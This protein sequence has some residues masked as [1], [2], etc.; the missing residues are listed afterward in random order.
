MLRYGVIADGSLRMA[1]EKGEVKERYWNPGDIF[2]EVHVLTLADDDIE[3]E[4]VQVMAGRG[5]LQIHPIGKPRPQDLLTLRRR[6]ADTL[7]QVAPD[8]I[9]GHGPFLQGYY[10]IGRAHV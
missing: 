7:R 6:A 8:I 4:R 5:R 10:E 9:R 3:P 1:Y 2:D